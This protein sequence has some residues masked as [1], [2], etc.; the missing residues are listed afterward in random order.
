MKNNTEDII[1]P[2]G[3]LNIEK[4]EPMLMKHS[5]WHGHIEFNYI[6]NGQMT[7]LFNGHEVTVPA[8]QFVIFWAAMAHRVTHIEHK[9]PHRA[10]ICN[11]YIPLDEF[12]FWPKLDIL[13]SELLSG[14]IIALKPTEQD[15]HRIEIWHKDFISAR[16]DLKDIMILEIQAMLRRALFDGRDNLLAHIHDAVNLNKV[17]KKTKP[18][19]QPHIIKMLQYIH[20]NYRQN[21][22]TA[23]VAE[24]IGF[25]GHYANKIFSSLLHMSI[26]KYINHLRLLHAKQLLLE[27][28]LPVSS[29]VFEAGF[30]S[31]SQFYKSFDKEYHLSPQS[32][33]KNI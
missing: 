24:H 19:I 15:L 33:R 13:R 17:N 7:Y 23:D 8:N 16:N 27:T 9:M 2:F 30:G 14:A 12:L 4:F 5:H 6:Y 20:Q 28:H 31:V 18:H 3:A 21:I 1:P 29:I 25:H 32:F 10:E 11:I 26:K 22:S